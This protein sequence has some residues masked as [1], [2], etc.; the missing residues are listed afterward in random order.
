MNESNKF[1]LMII[2][3]NYHDELYSTQVN[4]NELE[5]NFMSFSCYYY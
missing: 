1:V 2:K 3:M 5:L 4:M